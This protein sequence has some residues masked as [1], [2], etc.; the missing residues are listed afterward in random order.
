[1]SCRKIASLNYL[2]IMIVLKC[3][4]ALFIYLINRIL[5]YYVSCFG[6]ANMLMDIQGVSE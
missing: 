4:N 2:L 6:W 5:Q 3:L 1:M